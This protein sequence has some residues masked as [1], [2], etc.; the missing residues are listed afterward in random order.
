MGNE[1][2]VYESI[3]TGIKNP[4]TDININYESTIVDDN[5]TFKIEKT[6]CLLNLQ[7]VV[8]MQV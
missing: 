6:K 2:S 1:L 4:L 7:A 8:G 3:W 5:N